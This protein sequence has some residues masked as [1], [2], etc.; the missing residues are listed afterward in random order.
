MII[1][2]LLLPLGHISFTTIDVDLP[3]MY[4]KNVVR[5][6]VVMMSP[7]TLNKHQDEKGHY[8]DVTVSLKLQG[9]D[10]H[11]RKQKVGFQ[12]DFT[13]LSSGEAKLT[14]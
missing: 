9:Y 13:R 12:P 14:V 2:I 6:L 5:I 7:D 10:F 11:C 3:T 8:V 1:T 4:N